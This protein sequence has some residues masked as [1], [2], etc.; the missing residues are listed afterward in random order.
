M[1]MWTKFLLRNWRQLP[2][3]AVSAISPAA[4]AVGVVLQSRFLYTTSRFLLQ[5]FIHIKN[6]ATAKFA[7]KSSSKLI[8]EQVSSTTSSRRKRISMVKSDGVKNEE[9]GLEKQSP[10]K[11][12]G[13]SIR[14]LRTPKKF[15]TDETVRRF[16][17][18]S[19]LFPFCNL[20]CF[21]GF[22]MSS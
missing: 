19:F 3:G 13:K 15:W 14:Q 18:A 7:N 5:R 21:D 12:I 22:R 10:K 4:S 8:H 11:V 2:S 6:V 17:L 20:F 9:H 1:G 16:R